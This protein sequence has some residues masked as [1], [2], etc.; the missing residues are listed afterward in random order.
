MA[1]A[2]LTEEASSKNFYRK[3]A[4]AF[5]EAQAVRHLK[6]AG[7]IILEQNYHTRSG[8]IDIIA[9]DG[10]ELV[11]VEVKS[12]IS[13]EDIL[14]REAVNYTKQQHIKKAAQQYYYQNDFSCNCRFDV[15]EV[16]LGAR[17]NRLVALSINHIKEA[18]E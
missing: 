17:D 11:F 18:F 6:K 4:G 12:R 15:I 13:T 2:P 9:R 5:G 7:Y 8:E 1:P 3:E 10:E 14:P 16:Y